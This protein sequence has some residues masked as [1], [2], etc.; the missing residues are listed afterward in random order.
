M[1]QIPTRHP[2]E[3][4]DA[5]R[6]G[7]VRQCLKPFPFGAVTDEEEIGGLLDFERLAERSNQ[8]VYSLLA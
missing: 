6:R 7:V 5:L 1:T 3:E 4:P 2:A 8:R